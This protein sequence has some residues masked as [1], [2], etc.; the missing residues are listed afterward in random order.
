MASETAPPEQEHP[1]NIQL[2]KKPFYPISD[3]LTD[4][5]EVYGHTA[6]IPNLYHHLMGFRDSCTLFDANGEDTLWLTVVYEPMFMKPLSNRLARIYARLKTG[7]T[8]IAEHLT[9]ERI[10]FC[11]FGNSRPF[12]VRVV[13]QFNDNYDH[14]YVKVA[15]ANRIYGLEFEDILSPNRINYLVQGDT[16]IEEHIPGIPGDIFIETYFDQPNT[17]RV[18]LAKEFVKFSQRSFIRLLSI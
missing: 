14:F 16:L 4:Y 2:K 3:A 10:D 5:L 9:V 18:R 13:N 17:N 7:D 12:R 15:D 8:K 1:E 6:D 11:E